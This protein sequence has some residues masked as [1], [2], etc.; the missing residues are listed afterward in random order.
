MFLLR[1]CDPLRDRSRGS[2]GRVPDIPVRRHLVRE[3]LH[4]LL[5]LCGG[6]D[7]PV[8]V[9]PVHV[10]AVPTSALATACWEIS[11]DSGG[12]YGAAFNWTAD[13]GPTF[14]DD[15][16]IR[17]FPENLTDEGEPLSY[18]YPSGSGFAGYPVLGDVG[19][20]VGTDPPLTRRSN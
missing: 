4:R 9:G 18:Y 5:V 8:D 6:F 17:S 10:G 13:F 12:W 7:R 20:A 14:A 1:Q 11:N 2:W 16:L 15:G 19:I 3:R